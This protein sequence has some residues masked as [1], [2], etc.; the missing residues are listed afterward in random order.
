MGDPELR[1]AI[2]DGAAFI[3]M[4]I[5]FILVLF[6]ISAVLSGVG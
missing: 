5:G 2:R 3:G 4:A 6:V 1:E